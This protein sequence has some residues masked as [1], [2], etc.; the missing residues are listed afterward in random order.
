MSSPT[1]VGAL[2]SANER[3][4]LAALLCAAPLAPALLAAQDLYAGLP[5]PGVLFRAFPALFAIGALLWLWLSPD[6][7]PVREWSHWA[8]LGLAGALLLSSGARPEQTLPPLRSRLLVPA[9]IYLLAPNSLMR[10]A[11]PA[12]ILSLGHTLLRAIRLE[13]FP[14][15]AYANDALFL[16]VLNGAGVVRIRSR[17]LLEGAL[18]RAWQRENDAR[19]A[20][21]RARDE[22]RT[23]EGIIPICMHCRHL[24]TGAGEWHRLERYVRDHTGA[25]FSHGICPECLETHYPE[26]APENEAPASGAA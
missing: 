13:P 9:L 19:T 15:L 10:Q 26:P 8:V 17:L 3:R 11:G 20:A 12:I 23:L 7:R 6:D 5:L 22:V 18:E 16:I 24:R 25:Q 14:G 4:Q 21:E 1:V 2:R